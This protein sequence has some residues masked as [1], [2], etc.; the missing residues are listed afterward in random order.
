MAGNDDMPIF[1]TSKHSLTRVKPQAGLAALAWSYEKLSK[2]FHSY[3]SGRTL[4]V[5][6]NESCAHCSL[7]MSE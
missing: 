6:R 7:S 5:S 3:T 1:T 4:S 2:L